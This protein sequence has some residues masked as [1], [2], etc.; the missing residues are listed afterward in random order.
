MGAHNVDWGQGCRF[1]L[2]RQASSPSPF[3]FFAAALEDSVEVAL[4]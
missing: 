3:V 2:A 4:A 1:V